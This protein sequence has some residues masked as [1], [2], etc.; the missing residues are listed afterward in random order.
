MQNLKKGDKSIMFNSKNLIIMFALLALLA[1]TP[2]MAAESGSMRFN[3]MEDLHVAG[4][5]LVKG[6]Y[7]IKWQVEGTDA[8]VTF[9][10]SGK[11]E[12]VTVKGKVE[13][14]P[15]KY[16]YDSVG[17]AKD[18]SGKIIKQIQI[19]GKNIRIVF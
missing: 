5:A 2:I 4:E 13:E 7:E 9:I 11:K 8:S 1:A 16:D 12:I 17:F 10:R 6:Q 3:V 15:N 14:T 18:A 19:G